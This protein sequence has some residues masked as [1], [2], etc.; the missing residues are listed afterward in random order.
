[1][2][3]AVLLALAAVPFWEA[4]PPAEWSEGEIHELL[5]N[6]PWA[7]QAV[8]A[9]QS[10]G[11]QVY[12]ATA[13]PVREAERELERRQK[14]KKPAE[15]PNEGEYEEFLRENEGKYIVVAVQARI[16]DERMASECVLR[17][18]GKKQHMVGHFP[19]SPSDPWLR[20]V[21]PKVVTQGTRRFRVE[22]YVPGTKEPFRFAEFDT[23]EMRYQ[24]RFEI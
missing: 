8:S 11:V 15:D 5:T 6:S 24:G 3:W 9:K 10:S 19:P 17:V 16:A 7:Q 13:A 2:R 14:D 20:L 21:F 12:I 1:M 23:R 4:K 22:L 18:D